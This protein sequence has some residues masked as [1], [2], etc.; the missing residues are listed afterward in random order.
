MRPMHRQSFGQLLLRWGW[1][2]VIVACFG[3]SSSAVR[4]QEA[5]DLDATEKVDPEVRLVGDYTSPWGLTYTQ[6]EAVGLVTDLNGTG[7]D[8]LPS[9]RRATLHAEMQGRDVRSPNRVLASENTAIGL[10]RGY[11]PPGVRKGDRIDVEVRTP[12]KSE[13][14]SLRGG[15]LMQARLK[16]MAVLGNRIREGH[17]LALAEGP[18]LINALFEGGGDE[19]NE[20]RGRVLGGGVSMLSRDLGLVV[21]SSKK[22][23]R[24]SALIASA[25]NRRFWGFENGV[26]LGVATAKTDRFIQLKVDP[27]YRRNITRYV[28]ITRSIPIRISVADALVR[29]QQLERKLLESSTAARAAIDLEAMGPDGA[30]VL[31]RHL[32]VE[33]PVVSF[34]SAEALAYL[35]DE[36]GAKVIADAAAGEP[37]FRWR[38]FQALSA[39]DDIEAYDHLVELL[40]VSSAETRYGAFRALRTMNPKDSLVRGEVFE[41]AFRYHVISTPGEP[42]V[43]VT[44]YQHPEIVV[45]DGDLSLKL[46]LLLLSD[47]HLMVDGR[48]GE[49]I[50]VSRFSGASEQEVHCSAQLDEVIRAIVKLGG[51]Y[52]EVVQVLHDAKA[53]GHL[54]ARLVVDAL[55]RPDRKYR[56]IADGGDSQPVEEIP[57]ADAEKAGDGGLESPAELDT[58]AAEDE[59]L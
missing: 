20:V 45:F 1:G 58:F 42:M 12:S 10:V 44:R 34:C 39:L 25:V 43:H 29:T 56:Q 22:S 19:V 59:S 15:W 46:P 26:K 51:S 36:R 41:G 9:S 3:C 5:A 24:V 47:D 4:F 8:P 52:P 55:P 13:T 38:A 18:V 17:V 27:R 54:S 16:E 40:H 35:G 33:D 57:A 2:A 50:V 7:S 31:A 23:A 30:Q 11:L 21:R 32:E 28:R 49:T 14:T 37:A 6:V 48:Q 53:G